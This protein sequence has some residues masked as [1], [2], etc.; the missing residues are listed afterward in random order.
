MKNSCSCSPEKSC[1]VKD[2]QDEIDRM[3]KERA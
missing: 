1:A 3:R 2:K